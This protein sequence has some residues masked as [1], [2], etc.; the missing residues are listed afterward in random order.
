MPLLRNS[1]C[2]ALHMKRTLPQLPE[3]AK[4]IAR[5]LDDEQLQTMTAWSRLLRHRATQTR[6][7][8]REAPS[9]WGRIHPALEPMMQSALS[10]MG[11]RLGNVATGD[12]GALTPIMHP[13]V[14]RVLTDL[15]LIE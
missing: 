13:G 12:C 4:K 7:L 6:S 3:G 14:Y 5:Q 10:H 9:A 8:R 1:C 11:T 15:V 2:Y